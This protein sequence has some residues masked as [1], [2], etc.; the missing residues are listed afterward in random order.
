[1]PF[2]PLTNQL[3]GDNGVTFTH[4]YVSTPYCCPSRASLLT[5]LYAHN[6]GVIGNEAP[7]GGATLFDDSSTLATWLDDA[8]YRTGLVGKYLNDYWRVS[9]YVPPGWDQWFAL[10]NRDLGVGGDYQRY[11]LN[12]NGVEVNYSGTGSETY[13]T[14]VL[15]EKAVE[16]IR[17]TPLDQPLL[18]Y[19]APNAPHT[20]IIPDP[21]DA[22]KFADLEPYRPLS[23]N[24]ADVSDKPAWLQSRP[25]LTGTQL[26]EIDALY[27]LQALAL[28]PVDR[29]VQA[30]VDALEETGRL[31]NAVI[32]Y[33]TDNGYALGDHRLTRKN[34]VYEIC[35]K[36]PLLVRVPGLV[37][38]T[39]DHLVQNIDLPVTLA[40]FAG[41][42]PPGPVDG[43]SLVNLLYDPQSLWR[44]SVFLEVLDRPDLYIRN[45]QAVHT[46]QYVYAEYAN[47]DRELYDLIND[48]DQLLNQI[49]NP[50]YNSVTTRL[51]EELR[52]YKGQTDLRIEGSRST[53]TSGSR[54]TVNLAYTIMNDGPLMA[55]PLTLNIS[56]PPGMQLISCQTAPGSFCL[57]NSS[58]LEVHFRLL[59]P[60]QPE[61]VQI[62]V[63]TEGRESV[64]IIA[65]VTAFSPLESDPTNNR[66]NLVLNP[67]QIFF[68]FVHMSSP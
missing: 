51:A 46:G 62:V 26:E 3:L 18:L 49:D 50:A 20:I 60:G 38:R 68:P 33:T 24:E 29:A 63:A 64:E 17:T 66:V 41:I 30:I 61:D 10:S 40:G 34:C 15:R 19:F 55:A 35:V 6:H 36:V 9:P 7:V 37:P 22:G 32:V 12:E 54:S 47:G 2:M 48:P 5:G 13:S 4:A 52:S 65:E 14:N 44:E 53:F 25:L 31:S 58:V 23:Y 45:F 1:M 11:T 57:I 67:A 56:I 59:R 8:G 27:R 21:A 43:D 42:T 39:D 28:Q 16:F